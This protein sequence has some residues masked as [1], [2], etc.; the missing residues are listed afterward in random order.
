MLRL[1]KHALALA[2]GALVAGPA[3]ADPT[4]EGVIYQ[5]DQTGALA[6]INQVPVDDLAQSAAILQVDTSGTGNA[7]AN[8]IG[9]VIQGAV[10]GA[11]GVTIDPSGATATSVTSDAF[12]GIP[13]A[14]DVAPP[15]VID[16]TGYTDL[17]GETP[18]AYTIFGTA[19]N[20]YGLILQNGQQH[21][22]AVV[23]QSTGAES[24]AAIA[25]QD[26]LTDAGLAANADA[27]TAS[28]TVGGTVSMALQDYNNAAAAGQG[29]VVVN[30]DDGVLTVNYDGANDVQIGGGG[31]FAEPASAEGNLAFV[32]QGGHLTFNM[33]NGGVTI[34][35]DDDFAGTD[36]TNN[37][38]LV[39]Q[40]STNGYASVGQQGQLNSAAVLQ[41]GDSNAAESY[42]YQGDLDTPI[43][44]YSLIAQVGNFNLAQT[45]QGGT[46]NSAYVWQLGDGNISQ[47]DQAANSTIAFVYQSNN[48]AGGA[49]G[50]GNYA[51]VY[52][53]LAP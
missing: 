17:N 47:V 52:Q 37:L 34:D 28:A 4:T 26:S 43:S 50:T 14:T 36:D 42:Q 21:S 29:P 51:S 10:T 40:N 24:T 41:N 39:I 30:F 27:E 3:F 12:V 23:I 33:L 46:T 9:T 20:N 6:N 45:Y 1:K 53:H 19:S 15:T 44:N 38:A 48:A 22:Q 32:T 18:Y 49:P 16:L 8:N 5:A 13:G 11:G 25:A 31:L 7:D 2:V 35:T